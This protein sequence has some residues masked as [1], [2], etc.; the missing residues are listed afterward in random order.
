MV[1]VSYINMDEMTI[2]QADCRRSGSREGTCLS[3]DAENINP[4]LYAFLQNQG[5][6]SETLGL[7]CSGDG[8]KLLLYYLICFKRRSTRLLIN[9][10]KLLGQKV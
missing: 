9:L 10:F 4:I 5:E 2:D 8:L 1:H 6:E 7:Q 3:T